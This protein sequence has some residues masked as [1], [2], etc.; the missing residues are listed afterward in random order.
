M[1][2]Q[3][4]CPSSNCLHTKSKSRCYGLSKAKL[5]TNDPHQNGQTLTRVPLA[6]YYQIDVIPLSR[7]FYHLSM[8]DNVIG[9]RCSSVISPCI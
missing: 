8:A 3:A 7:P 2:L 1:V 9:F 5:D 6:F 4:L